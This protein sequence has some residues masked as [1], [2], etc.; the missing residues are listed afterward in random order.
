MSNLPAQGPTPR[1]LELLDYIVSYLARHGYQP[2]RRE[3]ADHCDVS[4]G[5]VQKRLEALARHGLVRLTGL[6][7]ALCLPRFSFSILPK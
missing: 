2:S 4:V 5:A 1:Q 7:R 3:M 6:D